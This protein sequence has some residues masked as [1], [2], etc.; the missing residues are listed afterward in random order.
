MKRVY[1]LDEIKQRIDPV[2]KR[3]NL[4]QVFLFGSY[5]R[6]EAT[7][8]SDVD[9]LVDTPD[10]RGLFQSEALRQDFAE[11]LGMNVDIVHMDGFLEQRNTH[12]EY[13]NQER[14]R[15]RKTVEKERV[16]LYENQG[17]PDIEAYRDIL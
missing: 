11:A 8:Q 13:L 16:M 9:L 1:T 10:I 14:E 17:Q 3:H 4:R 5:A 12:S 6:G 2:A 7:E 15:F